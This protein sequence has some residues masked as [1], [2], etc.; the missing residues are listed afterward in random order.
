MSRCVLY[1][2][3]LSQ[4]SSGY[5]GVSVVHGPASPRGALALPLGF[6]LSWSLW[7]W[8]AFGQSVARGSG[9]G[10]GEATLPPS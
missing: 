8:V 2:F 1:P 6:S 10:G 7:Q 9:G 3:D 4:G 5:S